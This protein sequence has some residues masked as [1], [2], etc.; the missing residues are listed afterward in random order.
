[1]SI[2]EKR[3]FT[4]IPFHT[5]IT[6][7]AAETT[8]VSNRL[9]DIGLGGAFVVIEG[10]I[11]EGTACTLDIDLIGPASL[12]R[13][14]VEG[15]VLRVHEEGVALKFTKIDLDSLLHLKH[16]IKVFTQDPELIHHEFITNLL[17]AE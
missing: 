11:P 9:R 14:Q 7:T 3:K 6:I 17:E 4:R 15:E 13:I 10:A 2:T 16:M 1:M 8:Y 12:L 5:K